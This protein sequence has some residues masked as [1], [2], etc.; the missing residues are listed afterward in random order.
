M[1]E[2]RAKYNTTN[3]TGWTLRPQTV[4]AVRAATKAGMDEWRII[5]QATH[6]ELLA[7]TQELKTHQTS[8]AAIRQRIADEAGWGESTIRLWETLEHKFADHLDELPPGAILTWSQLRWFPAIAKRQGKSESETF[9]ELLDEAIS[10][11]DREG[12]QDG[13]NILFACEA[14]LKHRARGDVKAPD[15]LEYLCRAQNCLEQYAKRVSGTGYDSM[16]TEANA[17]SA[18]IATLYQRHEKKA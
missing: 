13:E 5:A 17:I 3:S 16:A 14:V 11:R 1:T 15:P 7:A 10:R 9:V 8:K 4:R 12:S 6:E 2:Q 18:T